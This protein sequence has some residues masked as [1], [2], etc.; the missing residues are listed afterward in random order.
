MGTVKSSF[1]LCAA[2]LSSKTPLPQENKPGQIEIG[3]MLH[4]A[5]LQSQRFAET[6]EGKASINSGEFTRYW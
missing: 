1:V 3:Y 5:L 4:D 2:S 6:P